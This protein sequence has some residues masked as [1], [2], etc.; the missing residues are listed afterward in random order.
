MRIGFVV[1]DR[2]EPSVEQT[3]T[4]LICAAQRRGHEVLVFGVGDLSSG[5]D[6]R[7]FA[8]GCAPT[9]NDPAGLVSQ[10]SS[11]NASRQSLEDHDL[12]IVRP[13]QG[14]TPRVALNTLLHFA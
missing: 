2:R 7:L 6:G 13:I 1:N 3:T 9:E 8:Q 14:G 4:L 12:C 5:E 10:L 11:G